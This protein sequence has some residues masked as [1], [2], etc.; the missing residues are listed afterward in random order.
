MFAPSQKARFRWYFLSLTTF[1]LVGLTGFAIPTTNG[2]E[3]PP[4]SFNPDFDGNGTIDAKDLFIFTMFWKSENSAADFNGDGTVNAL[5]MLLFKEAFHSAIEPTPTPTLD[6]DP[7]P[8]PTMIPDTPTPTPTEPIVEDTPT[9]TETPV[10]GTPTPTPEEGT[11]VPTPTEGPEPTPTPIPAGTLFFTNF[12][13]AATLEDAGM[14]TLEG[15]DAEDQLYAENR[16][17]DA[18]QLFP[19]FVLNTE[20]LDPTYDYGVALSD[21]KCAALNEDHF[22]YYS[23]QTSVLEIK[24]PID[25]SSVSLPTL[26]FEAAFLTEI[27]EFAVNDFMVVEVKRSTSDTWEILDI[28]NDGQVIDDKTAFDENNPV[29]LL[30]DTFDGLFGASNPDN[31]EGPLTKDDFVPIEISLPSDP[32]LQIAFRFE[33]NL[34]IYGEGVYLDNIHVFDASQGGLHPT[35]RRVVNQDGSNIYADTET[36]VVIQGSRLTPAKKVIFTSRDGEAE[37]P[38][39]E[40]SDGVSV[41]L[42]R[43]SN[44]TEADN[45]TLKVIVEDDSET[46]SFGFTID[47]APAPQIDSISPSPFYLDASNATIRIYGSNFRPAFTGATDSGGTIVSIDTGIGE[48]IKYEFPTEFFKRTISEIA[49]DGSAL[50][51]LSPGP[52][53]I[54]LTNEYSGVQSDPF[55]LNLQSGS[56]DLQIE[57]FN[58]EIGGGAYTYD[59]ATEPFPLQQD[60]AF[61]LIWDVGGVTKEQLNIDLAGISFVVNGA[62]NTSVISERLNELGMDA[63]TASGKASLT[64][65]YSGVILELAPMIIGATGSIPADIRLANGDPIETTFALLDPQPPVIYETADDFASQ[66]W[67]TS[68][69]I[70]FTVYGDNFRKLKTWGAD[71]ESVTQL[72]L[73]P[74]DGSDPITLPKMSEFDITVNVGTDESNPDS[75]YQIIPTNFYNFSEGQRLLVPEGETLE[76]KLRVLNPD[77]G[78]YVDSERSITFVH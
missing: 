44:P 57:A 73:V 50:K 20:D 6:G 75:V 38:F 15:V 7:T 28:N 77:S 43:L 59:P 3:I 47:A 29:A 19:W 17:P 55:D 23:T 31:T 62:I 76:F 35:I 12:D 16:L 11:P 71:G 36:R 74:L 49:F 52:V 21:P 54:T 4:S 56:G 22:A 8:T 10:P 18:N 41:V 67:S 5:D 72:Q 14:A 58:I 51:T 32:S 30:P 25:T 37:L 24:D 78:A 68:E 39:S 60:Q 13:A 69:E 40:T 9:P 2:Q 48:P 63:S 33:S 45:A 42:P 70:S 34:V 66:E 27:P 53:T 46:S 65:G 61:S 64:V 26:T 1:I